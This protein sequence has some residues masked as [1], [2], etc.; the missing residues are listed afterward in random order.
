MVVSN[1]ANESYCLSCKKILKEMGEKMSNCKICSKQFHACFSCGLDYDWQFYYC[2]NNCWQ[3][4][5]EHC[6]LKEYVDTWTQ[7]EIEKFNEC[8]IDTL[9]CMLRERLK[10]L[11]YGPAEKESNCKAGKSIKIEKE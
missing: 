4:S 2:S 1:M 5:K 8:D 9:L 3:L 7:E 6:E 11:K 10:F